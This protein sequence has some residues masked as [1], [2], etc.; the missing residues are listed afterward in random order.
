MENHLAPLIQD[1]AIILMAAAVVSVIFK[2]IKQPLVLG[3]I[4]AG[5]LV[6][7][8]FTLFPS[9]VDEHSVDTWAEIGVIF[10]LFSLGLEFSFKKL[11][12]V[13]GSASITALVEI[14]FICTLGFFVG[15]WM[16][17]ST[18]DSIFL[19]GMLASSSTTI[20][21][22]AFDEL[23]VKHQKFAGIVFG[24]LVVEDIVVIILM[25]LL[26]TMA[27]SQQFNGNELMFAIAK[28]VFFLIAIYLIGIYLLPTILRKAKKLLDDETLLIISIGLCFLLVVLAVRAGLSAE[29]GAFVMGTILAETTFAERIE[30]VTK[31]T[32]DLFG[33]VFFVSIGMMINPS[34]LY[35]YK[36][37]ILIVTLVV[38]VGKLISTTL[39][40]VLSGQPLRQSVQVG[41]S[42][43]QIGEFA[44]IV[45]A[46]GMSLNVIS[47]FL[48]PVAVGVSAV[49]TFTTPYMIK[50]SDKMYGFVQRIL[51][52]KLQ[53]SIDK[54]SFQ[55]Q[56]IQQ[57]SSW[58][59]L[60]KAYFS[61]ILINLVV[62]IA[63]VLLAYN[64]I[65]PFFTN[66]FFDERT[67]RGITL[68]I[69]LVTCIPFLWP[70]MFKRIHRKEYKELW[71]HSYLS[72]SPLIL[73]DILRIALGIIILQFIVYRFYPSFIISVLLIPIAFVVIYLLSTKIDYLHNL[74][75]KRFLFNFYERD[76]RDKEKQREQEKAEKQKTIRPSTQINTFWDTYVTDFEVGQYGSYI[77][78]RL[79]DLAWREN[80]GINVAYIKRGENVIYAPNG[81]T[82]IFPFDHIGLIGTEEQ[83]KE[84]ETK[85][86]LLEEKGE[87]VFT[88]PDLEDFTLM[89][90]Q[91]TRT[92]PFIG[93]SIKET[94]LREKTDGLVVGIERGEEK[95]LNP[96]STTIL[97]MEDLV[98]L[99]GNRQMI[100][101]FIEENHL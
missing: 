21:L 79:Q 23:K 88:Q 10:L 86:F 82:R 61:T 26:S 77:G 72:R 43:A 67:S 74:I 14:I 53:K 13:G 38:I 8:Y 87:E 30:H 22:K 73:M 58:R 47:D 83:I 66:N 9:V 96:P 63:I 31:P 55:F 92:A 34:E 95:I 17:W 69:V 28:L 56:N 57:E 98:Y 70:I 25:V 12:K 100:K 41:M 15:Q 1:L 81:L 97:Q 64:V 27:V 85:K 93:Q 39:G 78:K 44:F 6:G 19:A 2:R 84:F 65:L 94:Q 80:Y 50:T 46:L 99:V 24:V 40:A 62:I 51:P 5:F 76:L 59:K 37:E 16:G 42:M 18:M 3:Y 49:T 32:K 29:L 45:A 20:I 68:G 7:P 60:M 52:D 54:Y 33:A 75:V 48:F 91:V 36:W 90:F 89:N 4:I 71:K 11:I 101:Q 35:T